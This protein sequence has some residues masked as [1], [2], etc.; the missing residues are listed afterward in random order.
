MLPGPA[1]YRGLNYFRCMKSFI[2]FSCVTE[3]V[4]V[5]A[6]ALQQH[7]L[8]TNSPLFIPS[9]P[10]AIIR[11]VPYCCSRPRRSRVSFLPLEDGRRDNA[12]T[13]LTSVDPEPRG[14]LRRASARAAS[15]K[16]TA[17]AAPSYSTD[18]ESGDVTQA[19]E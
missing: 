7:A 10:P 8:I 12:I 2:L 9:G 11:R 5:E 6:E 13:H 14:T 3:D 4:C 17:S 16:L 15:S 1:T 18:G 19:E